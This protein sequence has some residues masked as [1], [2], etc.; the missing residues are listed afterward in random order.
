MTWVWK[1][2]GSF[3]WQILYLRGQDWKSSDVSW[4]SGFPGCWSEEQSEIDS[5]SLFQ[6]AFWQK[7]GRLWG[8]A[9]RGSNLQLSS[10]SWRDSGRPKLVCWWVPRT[11]LNCATCPEWPSWTLNQ[12]LRISTVAN[13]RDHDSNFCPNPSSGI[14]EGTWGHVQQP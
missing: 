3:V 4:A 5:G 2:E 1:A 13:C 6:L 8:K 14:Q 10:C 11:F 12:L 9:Q 7:L